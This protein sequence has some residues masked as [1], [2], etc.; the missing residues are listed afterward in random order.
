MQQGGHQLEEYRVRNQEPKSEVQIY[1]W[2]D[3]TLRELTV[4][5]KRDIY[6][7][8]FMTGHQSLWLSMMLR[9]EHAFLD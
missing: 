9:P 3:A 8:L 5:V 6:N 7:V 1:T 2:A 4:L